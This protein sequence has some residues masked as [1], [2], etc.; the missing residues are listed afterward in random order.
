MFPNVRSFVAGVSGTTGTR[1]GA[2]YY[3]QKNN[4]TYASL[5][6][7]ISISTYPP[8]CCTY[9]HRSVYIYIYIVVIVAVIV[10]RSTSVRSSRPCCVCVIFRWFDKRAARSFSRRRGRVS[11]IIA[12]RVYALAIHHGHAHLSPA[13][14]ATRRRRDVEEED[15]RFARF[16]FIT[17][18]FVIIITTTI[19]I[20]I[21]HIYRYVYYYYRYYHIGTIYPIIRN[22][23]IRI[24][25]MIFHLHERVQQVFAKL[26]IDGDWFKFF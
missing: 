12:R 20:F 8:T 23:T 24:R 16:A 19:I 4:N 5:Y 3:K 9:T 15:V 26:I 1:Y 18:I 17:R 21:L 25:P 6:V 22:E 11:L 7:P 2:S 10:F 13:A 14:V